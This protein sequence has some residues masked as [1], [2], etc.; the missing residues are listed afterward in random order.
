M[1]KKILNGATI[2][3]SPGIEAYSLLSGSSKDV[4]YRR[5]KVAK[6]DMA[7]SVIATGT[8]SA[9]THV[10]VGTQ[11]PGTIKTLYVDFNSP[12]KKDQTIALTDPA[13]FEAQVEQAKATLV[14]AKANADKAETAFID[15]KRTTDRNR[16]VF[17][18]DLIARSDL[19][20]SETKMP[21]FS[22]Y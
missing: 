3:I 2:V 16:A 13:T 6:G 17:A 5:E 22:V 9:I 12:V 20:T 11:V 14:S 18:Q 21:Y 4:Q 8:P 1:S 10:L 7:D 19:D 15:A